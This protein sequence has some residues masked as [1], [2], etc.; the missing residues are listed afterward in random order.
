[1]KVIEVFKGKEYSLNRIIEYYYKIV[2]GRVMIEGVSSPD[3]EVVYG[4]QIDKVL[5]EKNGQQLTE[6]GKPEMISCNLE[7]VK[8]ICKVLHKNLVSPA[9]LIDVLDDNLGK[10]FKIDSKIK[11]IENALKI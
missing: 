3:G 1:M 7:L 8:E 11:F 10:V 5:I 2:E 9:H 4:V 6:T